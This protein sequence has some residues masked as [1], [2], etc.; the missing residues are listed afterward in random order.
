MDSMRTRHRK[1]TRKSRNKISTSN[2]SIAIEEVDSTI[3]CTA[4]RSCV[5]CCISGRAAG[6]SINSKSKK[7]VANQDASKDGEGSKW[8]LSALRRH[9]ESNEEFGVSSWEDQIWSQVR[10]LVVKAVIAV[11]AKVNTLVKMHVPGDNCFELYGADVML[12][13]QLRAWLIEFNTGPALNT[14]TPLDK[15]VKSRVVTD[16]FHIVGFTAVDKKKHERS[17]LAARQ[18]RLTGIGPQKS[19]ATHR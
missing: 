13:S 16:M 19:S 15:A 4:S 5:L 9:L 2:H 7:F 8:T 3:C 14:P 17:A 12:N 1:I 18:N 6:N 11:D 10:D